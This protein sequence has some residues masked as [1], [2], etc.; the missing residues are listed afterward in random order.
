MRTEFY[1]GFGSR[2]E[3]R[4]EGELDVLPVEGT[5]VHITGCLYH[6]DRVHF[7]LGRLPYVNIYLS[8]GRREEQ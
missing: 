6:V 8:G 7:Y 2:R 4:W 5:A 3:K 1:A